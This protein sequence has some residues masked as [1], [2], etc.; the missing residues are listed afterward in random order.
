MPPSP[1][2]AIHQFVAGFRQGDA[3]SNA[4]TLMQRHFRSWGRD[5]GIFCEKRRVSPHERE[6]VRDQA[7]A[8]ASLRPDDVAI[9]HLSIG[10]PVNAVFAKLRC[11]KA[12]IYHNVTPARYFRLFNPALAE[13]LAEGR[14]QAAA[15]AGTAEVNLAVS[16]YNAAELTAMGYRDV[17]VL[18]LPINLA[19]ID[20]D[21]ADPAMRRRLA[22]GRPNVLFVG[23]CV[24]NKR[25]ED[26]LTVMHHLRRHV[27]P[28]A[29]LVHVGSH[30]GTEAYFGLLTAR[31]R[32]LGLHD[33]LF[34]GSVSQPQLNACYAT[35]RVLLCLSEHEGFCAPLLEAMLHDVPVV[36]RAAAAVPET[37]AGAGV[38]LRT[39]DP[40]V[41]AE[42]V[43]RVLLDPALRAAI[44]ARQ[45]ARV[46]AWR[47]R[48]LDREL[49]QALAPLL[50]TGD[51]A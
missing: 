19:A 50:R 39:A 47:A 41:A 25:I 17:D 40:A 23:R 33:T 20:P 2:P 46:A 11:R 38:L 49:R 18:P 42:T 10:S 22:D 16:A 28:A 9:L 15:L 13:Q 34:L 48:D 24:P 35:A 7:E 27:L 6:H 51:A 31:A 26:L 8:E 3:I 32:T 45:Q 5:A 1:P 14:R 44:L 21:Q 37:L 43:G 12:I 4:A 29:R 30:A 36:A